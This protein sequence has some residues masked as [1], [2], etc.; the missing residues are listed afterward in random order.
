[1]NGVVAAVLTAARS[2]MGPGR[3]ALAVLAVA[4]LAVGA[5]ASP[6]PVPRKLVAPAPVDATLSI[7]ITGSDGLTAYRASDGVKRWT[8]ALSGQLVGGPPVPDAGAGITFFFTQATLN[9]STILTALRATDGHFLW[10]LPASDPNLFAVDGDNVVLLQP[11]AQSD[12]AQSL[13]ILRAADGAQEHVIPLSS[14][15]VRDL[16]ADGGAAYVCPRSGVLSAYRL[17]DGKMI[18][19]NPITPTSTPTPSNAPAAQSCYLM[20]VDGTLYANID[21]QEAGAADVE[22]ALLAVRESDGHLLW[23]QPLTMTGWLARD[24]IVVGVARQPATSSAFAANTEYTLIVLRAS[25]GAVLWRTPNTSRDIIFFAASGAVVTYVD[26]DILR[27]VSA[28]NGTPLWS[29]QRRYGLIT[30]LIDVAGADGVI[31][32]ISQ[33]QSG[34]H[35]IPPAGTDM[36]QYLLALRAS[37]GRMYWQIPLPQLEN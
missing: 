36:N 15:P 8:Y 32:A 12:S 3:R 9:S 19:Q 10:S 13:L 21:R 2:L 4:V 31:F 35:D 28:I 1:M 26:G 37:D 27:G 34:I 22:S 23:R 7:Y 33:A 20:A 29:L 6:P 5:C 11:D 16:T 30:P 17:R 18:W 24:R 25:D 14:T